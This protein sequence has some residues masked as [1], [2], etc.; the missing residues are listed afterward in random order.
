[1]TN[2]SNCCARMQEGR[3]GRGE[4]EK[5]GEGEGRRE[6]G[7]LE[8]GGGEGLDCNLNKGK[9]KCGEAYFLS[10][11]LLFYPDYIHLC[12]L[13]TGF[14]CNLSIS[15]SLIFFSFFFPFTFSI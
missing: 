15:H 4:T 2:L 3:R 1:M 7:G 5:G 13:S 11:S 12:S 8:G 14:P 9:S 10:F 6:E